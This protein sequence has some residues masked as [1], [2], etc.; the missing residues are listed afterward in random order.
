MNHHFA[1][2]L[3]ATAALLAP[4]SA[5]AQEATPLPTVDVTSEPAHSDS[6]GRRDH[7]QIARDSVRSSDTASILRDLPGLS[8][9]DAGGFASLPVIRGF[10]A[11]RIAI[12][13]DGV[14]IDDVCPN[15]M[16]PPLSFTDPQTVRTIVALTG[17]T[18][19]SMGG[20]A[21]GGAI[22]VETLPPRFAA[23]GATLL[24][25]RASTFFRSN[26]DGFGGAFSVTA[27]SDKLSLTYNGS[28]TESGNYQG[29]GDDGLVRSSEYAK[30]DHALAI[31]A[32][33]DIGQFELKAGIQRAPFEGFTN[34]YMDM[35]DNRS[36][37]VSGRY[38][39]VFDWGD[40]DFT[41]HYRDTDH[42]MNFL[43]D[44]GG[45]ADGGM[46]MLT[47]THTAGYTLKLRVQLS[48]QDTLG[49]GSEFHHQWLNDFWPPVAGSMMMGPN[50]YVNL[51]RA[52]RDRLGSYLEWERA[53]TGQIS[54]VLGIRND[55]LWM[56]TG[57]VQPYSTGMMSMVDAAAAAAFNTAARARSDSNWSGSAILRY[58]PS[59]RVSAE[60]GF[61]R[62]VRSP[63]L[64]ER[65]SWGRGSMSSR[66]VGWFG[67]GNGYVG[68]LELAPERA[69]SLSA[70]LTLTGSGDRP[71][72]VRISPH[73]THVADYIDV[74]K[75]KDLSGAMG[76]P[77]GFV[78][79]Q[80]ANREA[81]LFGA[82][83]SGTVPLWENTRAGN[84]SLS[85]AA[86]WIRGD[87]LS[88]DGALYHQMPF[89]ANLQLEHKLGRLESRIALA[90]VTDKTR[91][92][93]TR[94]EPETQGYAVVNLGAGYRWKRTRLSLDVENLFDAAYDLPL[95]G[96]SLGDYRATGVTRPVPGRGRSINLGLSVD[97]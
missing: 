59:S 66:M 90:W 78:Q 10:E 37:F 20:D 68:D 77:T 9:Y 87:N 63:N 43:D 18:P 47:E 16:A 76:R 84:A 8:A 55:Q 92:D 94:N 36:W 21:I 15:K 32:A 86:S 26:G 4:L 2:P 62:K 11:D 22:S 96:I 54:T 65:Y 38:Q 3:L 61:A 88:D 44:K 91:V 6:T 52:T 75:L 48:S 35:T 67:D 34:Q 93:T 71:W 51:N 33:T 72:T 14:K 46:P 80:F 82:D 30:T 56:N 42:E 73:L 69:D 49:L 70:A 45:V 19:V 1:S 41:A 27:A 13:V 60:L 39:G 97:F 89:N 25:A 17:A 12:L 31:S 79:L 85:F 23:A 95:G 29:G 81:R 83:L 64:Y 7:E 53:W 40:L 50:T 74:V 57:E 28:Y 24:T 58:A 5:F